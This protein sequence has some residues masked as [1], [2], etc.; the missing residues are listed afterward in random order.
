M[1]GWLFW[2]PP[3]LSEPPSN[4]WFFHLDPNLCGKKSFQVFDD[5]FSKKRG[6]SNIHHQLKVSLWL[7]VWHQ[8][9]I[10][11]NLFCCRPQKLNLTKQPLTKR[12]IRK[13]RIGK[14]T[15]T[16]TQPQWDLKQNVSPESFEEKQFLPEVDEEY[17]RM[18]LDEMAKAPPCFQVRGGFCFV[19]C[20]DGILMDVKNHLNTIHQ[21]VKSNVLLW[22]RQAG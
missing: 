13:K 15:H 18:K 14:N 7:K 4:H 3:R 20:V 5:D 22:F 8:R 1:L 2:W 17:S 21:T 11:R 6:G 19:G 16:H 10:T 9:L 12:A